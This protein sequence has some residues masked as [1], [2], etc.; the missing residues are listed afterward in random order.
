MRPPL[1]DWDNLKIPPYGEW[2]VIRPDGTRHDGEDISLDASGKS[3]NGKSVV[4]VADGVIGSI[5]RSQ[6]MI[7]VEHGNI[8]ITGLKRT[9]SLMT[10]YAHMRDIP[11]PFYKGK[12]LVEGEPIG[13]VDSM[14]NVTGPH[15]HFG[16]WDKNTASS[17]FNPELLFT[18]EVM[19]NFDLVN[20]GTDLYMIN[21]S[22]DRGTIESWGSDGFQ[23]APLNGGTTEQKLLII[24][25]MDNN[26]T[27]HV[28]MNGVTKDFP[29]NVIPIDP[30]ASVKLELEK[31]KKELEDTK[32]K[33]LQISAEKTALQKEFDEFKATS[34]L[35]EAGLQKEIKSL[36]ETNTGLTEELGAT[37]KLLEESKS[38][39]KTL[40]TKVTELEDE[41]QK[42]DNMIKEQTEKIENQTKE[43]RS[44]TAKLIECEQQNN[45]LKEF[46]KKIWDWIKGIFR[47]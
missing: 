11:I 14:G 10:C 35:K 33:V 12:K 18:K 30:C 21:I 19:T 34:T 13:T 7:I 24:M 23:G 47:K 9:I 41:C 22:G 17:D 37:K 42:K 20:E 2:G 31:V 27:Y 29:Y 38:E 4:V 5:D 3:L 8:Y 44:L 43:I 39:N 40:N 15:L 26:V 25:G 46:L 36:K 1:S 16:T 45:K 28:K 6:G 32:K